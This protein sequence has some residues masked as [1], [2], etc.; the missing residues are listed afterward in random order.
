MVRERGIREVSSTG[1]LLKEMCLFDDDDEKLQHRR[2]GKQLFISIVWQDM[3]MP[4]QQ[5]HD[6]LT[7]STTSPIPDSRSSRLAYD[8]PCSK[9]AR[10][11]KRW[12][13]QPLPE[14]GYR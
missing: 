9:I 4:R 14:N 2:A 10:F 1:Y 3:P 13:R 5:M 7:A 6:V 12:V 8:V 11:R